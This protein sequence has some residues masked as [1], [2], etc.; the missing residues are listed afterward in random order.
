MTWTGKS[1]ECINAE[2]KGIHFITPTTAQKGA[3]LVI[4]V[5]CGCGRS[6]VKV[7]DFQMGF[8]VRQVGGAWLAQSVEHATL[9]LG[10]MSLSP[11]LGIDLT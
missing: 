10:V 11:V 7:T 8:R 6:C 4:R 1:T 3:A 2:E 9:D 5:E